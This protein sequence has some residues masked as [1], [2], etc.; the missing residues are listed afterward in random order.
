M[1]KKVKYHKKLPAHILL[2]FVLISGL[3]FSCTE[4]FDFDLTDKKVTLLSPPDKFETTKASWQFKWEPVDFADKYNIQI[5]TPGFKYPEHLIL[6]TTISSSHLD[7]TLFPAEFE[8]RVKAINNSY[9]TYYSVFK[10]TV[11]ST[12]DISTEN[13]QLLKPLNF[14]TTNQYIKHFS[15][16]P[17]YNAYHYNFELW[18]EDN[19][20][21][22]K[23]TSEDTLRTT[24]TEGE[25]KY[26]WKVQG[27][28]DNS[29]TGLFERHIFLDTTNPARPAPIEPAYNAVLYDTIV[30]FSWTRNEDNGARIF[31]TLFIWRDN[32][33]MDPIVK[34]EAAINSSI[35]ELPMGTYIWSVKSYDKAGNQ[36]TLGTQCKFLVVNEK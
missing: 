18:F 2:L 36:S 6:D 8:W 7:Y 29:Q 4:I 17:L 33:S 26:V 27:S 12:S 3:P 31:D 15:W 23:T 22:Q 25:G 28:N 35:S 16:L 21:E 13:V 30:H 20:I 24:L 32:L 5:S 10:L 11:D 34:I 19:L 9:E 1:M 14:D